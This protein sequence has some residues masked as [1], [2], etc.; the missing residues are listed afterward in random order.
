ATKA[1][2]VLFTAEFVLLDKYVEAIVPAI[3]G[4]L[5]SFFGTGFASNRQY[6]SQFGSITPSNLSN[7]ILN[8]LTYCLLKTLSFWIM[9][10]LI[11]RR[12]GISAIHLVAFGLLY[13]WEAVYSKILTWVVYTT[14]T[15][16][17][18]LGTCPDFTFQFN[19]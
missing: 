10:H 16:L 14:Q 17:Q 13:Q 19:W 8:V 5:R 15:S 7:T 9:C 4:E 2:R 1:A 18:H 6:Y 11:S 3:Y 12:V